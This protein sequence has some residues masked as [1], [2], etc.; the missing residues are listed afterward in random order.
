MNGKEI[1]PPKNGVLLLNIYF[2]SIV[3]LH[4][5]KCAMLESQAHSVPLTA[6]N[7]FKKKQLRK[8]AQELTE[9]ERYHTLITSKITKINLLQN[10]VYFN[11]VF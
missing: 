9:R 3:I 2:F 11:A 1:A 6:C 5:C 4:L 10:P 8:S 7:E